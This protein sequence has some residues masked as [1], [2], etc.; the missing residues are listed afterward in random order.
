M[1]AV[2]KLGGSVA[3]ISS[4]GYSS[5]SS[6]NYSIKPSVS[7]QGDIFWSFTVD[8]AYSYNGQRAV[9]ACR[10]SPSGEVLW[11]KELGETVNYT[12]SAATVFFDD[13]TGETLIGAV[14]TGDVSG[15]D[16]AHVV[17][18][19][20]NGQVVWKRYMHLGTPS[21]A[22]NTIRPYMFARKNAD[23]I[24]LISRS[25]GNNVGGNSKTL[26][27]LLANDTGAMLSHRVINSVDSDS[28]GPVSAFSYADGSIMVQAY[29]ANAHLGDKYKNQYFVL[30]PSNGVPVE[31]RGAVS[32]A[33]AP[34]AGSTDVFLLPESEGMVGR[35]TLS[36]SMVWDQSLSIGTSNYYEFI[37]SDASGCLYAARYVGTSTEVVKYD[38]DGNLLNQIAIEGLKIENHMVAKNEKLY[39]PGSVV[40]D[41]TKRVV[42]ILSSALDEVGEFGDYTI[43]NTNYGT[44]TGNTFSTSSESTSSQTVSGIFQQTGIVDVVD[45]GVNIEYISF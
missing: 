24:I 32:L 33:I 18:L 39:I 5:G 12:E 9:F 35:C 1:L 27:M 38:M 34:I 15:S 14:A 45:A 42:F 16:R 22:S 30:S 31:S 13:S 40:G 23:E 37:A 7:D 3:I 25:Y 19:D 44:V 29:S 4:N 2:S 17:K 10:V 41:Y 8:S 6:S 28:I 11:A 21:S 43:T 36:G 26:W 20:S